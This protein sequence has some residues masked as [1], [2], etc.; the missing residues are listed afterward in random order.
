MNCLPLNKIFIFYYLL[1]LQGHVF[2][3]VQDPMFV[4]LKGEPE[5]TVTIGEENLLSLTFLI[6]EGYHIQAN[7]VHDENLIPSE[8]S[9]EETGEL[10]LGDPVYPEAD[11]LQMEGAKETLAVFGD[12]VEIKVPVKASETLEKGTF[13]IEGKL[14]YQPCDASKCY[15]PREFVFCMKIM[16]Q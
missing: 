11:E 4:E 2:A 8:L 13:F 7:R 12:V 6:K 14:Y 5:F 10:R 16:V 1:F 3:Q 15:F 9:F